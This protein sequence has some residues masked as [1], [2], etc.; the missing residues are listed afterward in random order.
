MSTRVRIFEPRCEV[1]NNVVCATSKDSDQPAHMRVWSEILQV[2]WIFYDSWATDRTSF[3]VSKLK[4]RLNKL[5]WVDTCQ[6]ATL[7]EIRVS[8]WFVFKFQ[9][10]DGMINDIHS[11]T[12]SVSWQS[13]ESIILV[14]TVCWEHVTKQTT[15]RFKVIA[16]TI[17]WKY[18]RL[19][20]TVCYM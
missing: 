12:A 15:I 11:S 9:V 19:V 2:A 16:M 13:C 20:W 7:M 4:R 6:N 3:G 5:I 8:I 18:L 17:M 1:S 10:E 14:R